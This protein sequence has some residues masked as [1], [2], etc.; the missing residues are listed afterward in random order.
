MKNFLTVAA[1][2]MIL[3]GCKQTEEVKVDETKIEIPADTIVQ[4]DTIASM[5]II[6]E[7]KESAATDEKPSEIAMAK[8][9]V[10]YA[11]FGEKFKADNVFSKER[12]LKEYSNLKKGDTVSVK[13]K[14]D[15]KSV[16]K[17]KGCWMK[18]DL[19]N[20]QESF[21]R[22]KDYGFFV[23]LNADSS[24]AIVS[25]KAYIDVVSVAELQH[26]AKDGGKSQEEIDKIT[27]PKVTYAFLADG[28]MIEE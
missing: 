14:S 25:G 23:P 18:M 5:E 27:E 6:E 3:A 12:M 26:Y 9:E 24:P 15:I 21:V 11:S 22:F 20:N 8:P 28:V 2:M 19:P 10:S 4:K 13:F 1:L 16:C 7:E 17:K